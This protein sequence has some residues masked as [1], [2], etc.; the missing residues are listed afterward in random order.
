MICRTA[1]AAY[2]AGWAD[3][4]HDSLMTESVRIRLIAL[5]AP[6]FRAPPDTAATPESCNSRGRPHEHRAPSQLP[7]QNVN[8]GACN[9]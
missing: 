7:N 6:H 9:V 1:E 2:A 4:E 3:G 5:H 8:P